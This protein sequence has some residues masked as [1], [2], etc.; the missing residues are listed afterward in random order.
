M[1]EKKQHSLYLRNWDSYQASLKKKPGW[2]EV[3][4]LQSIKRG[5]CYSIKRC[6]PTIWGVVSKI[7]LFINHLSATKW[8]MTLFQNPQLL[9][10]SCCWNK[11]S[12]G[13]P[14]FGRQL[15]H[16]APINFVSP[17][18]LVRETSSWQSGEL[19]WMQHC[20]KHVRTTT[21]SFGLIILGKAWTLVW[22]LECSTIAQETWVQSQVES[23]QRLKNDTWWL[24]DTQ[25]YKLRI[26]GEVEQSREISLSYTMV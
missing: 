15:Q 2:C 9:T 26:K 20:C 6:L 25:H 21:F 17:L 8:L 3:G 4:F 23:C 1:V 11:G 5:S 16:F 22:W 18:L 19:A 24:L 12:L 10:L 14:G 13:S 7:K